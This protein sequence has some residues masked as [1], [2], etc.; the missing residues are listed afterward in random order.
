MPLFSRFGAK[1]NPSDHPKFE[2]LRELLSDEQC[3]HCF[4][5]ALFSEKVQVPVG[6]M[7]KVQEAISLARE[8]SKAT[9][10]TAE[11]LYEEIQEQS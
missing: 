11:K 9:G 2:R 4:V 5:M 1:K 7:Q 10:V 8:I 6:Q 3:D